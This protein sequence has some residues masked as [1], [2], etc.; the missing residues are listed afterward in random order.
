MV[1]APA[2]AGKLSAFAAVVPQRASPILSTCRR[3]P[4]AQLRSEPA[5]DGNVKLRVDCVE[6]HSYSFGV[7][8]QLDLHV[9]KCCGLKEVSSWNSQ[10]E[11]PG[12]VSPEVHAV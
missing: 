6:V 4:M 9:S 1:D 7:L 10:R 5:N 8:S 12:R 11:A 2:M 3:A